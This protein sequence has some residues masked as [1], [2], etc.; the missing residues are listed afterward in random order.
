MFTPRYHAI[1][2]VAVFLALGIGVVLGVAVGE[3]GIVSS[4]S[5]DLEKS[6]RGDLDQARGRASE[7][8]RDLAQR[9]DF[10]RQAYPALVGGLLPDWRIGIVAMNRLPSGY[11]SEIRDAVEPAGATIESVSVVEAPLPLDRAKGEL[12]GTKLER[13]ERDDEVLERFGRRIGRQLAQGGQLVRRL[14]QEIFSTSRG[15]YEGVDGIVLVRD[16]DELKG[17]DKSTQDRFESALIDAAQDTDVEVVGVEKTDTDPSQVSVVLRPG[18]HERGL[19]RPH[20]GQDGAGLRAAR[21]QRQVRGEGLGRAPAAPAPGAPGD[22]EVADVRWLGL[23][24]S[25]GLAALLAPTL[26][27]R[28]QAAGVVRENYRGLVLPAASGMLI[29]VTAAIVVGPLAALEELADADTLAPEVGLALVFVLGVGVLGLVDDLLGGPPPG[30]RGRR[31]ERA[32]RRART[33]ARRLPRR[34][35]HRAC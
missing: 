24:A 20:R 10:E 23:A 8:R 31:P 22:Q 21:R 16:P 13:V 26:L 19:H 15:N 32:P 17:E 28:L 25:L 27:A 2:L 29:A 34:L 18:R 4:A 1:S 14:R 9:R 35:Q 12:D 33:P 30:R 3:E 6:L 5:R 11:V 7:L